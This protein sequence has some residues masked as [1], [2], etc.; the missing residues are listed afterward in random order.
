MT[1][2]RSL[3]QI[4]TCTSG[5]SEKPPPGV[6]LH[7]LPRATLIFCVNVVPAP[8][9]GPA[10]AR[11]GTRVAGGYKHTVTLSLLSLKIVCEEPVAH[12]FGSALRL[13]DVR[14]DELG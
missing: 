11:P 13:A 10:V 14:A 1:K 7:F 2:P 4:W 8:R 5:F 3:T 9:Y 12:G 6:G